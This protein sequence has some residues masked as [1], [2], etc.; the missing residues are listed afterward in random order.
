MHELSAETAK[1]TA[2]R[3]RLKDAILSNLDEVY[4][5]GSMEHRAARQS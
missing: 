1:L 4:V 5:N 3:D 2:L